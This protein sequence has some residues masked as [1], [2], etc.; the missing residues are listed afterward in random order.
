LLAW[1]PVWVAVF[2]GVF[3]IAYFV[4]RKSVVS[5][6][7]SYISLPVAAAIDGRTVSEVVVLAVMSAVVSCLHRR[8]AALELRGDRETRGEAG[9]WRR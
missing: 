3:L 2:A 5:A 4:S 7:A 8:A 1:R 9:S 6:M